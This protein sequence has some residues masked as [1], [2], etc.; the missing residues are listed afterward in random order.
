MIHVRVAVV[1]LVCSSVVAAGEAVSEFNGK[2]AYSRGSMEGDCGQNVFGSFSLPIAD[3]FGFQADGLYTNVSDR[4][5]YGAGGHLFWR[6]WDKGL[7]GIA[8][9]VL[10]EDDID[11]GLIV[12]EGEY[13][14]N[15]F[16]VTAAAGVANIDY[17]ESVP[18][19]ESDPTDFLGSLGLRCYPLDDLMLAGAY[20]YV[21]DNSL[22]LGELEYQTPIDGLTLFAEFAGG[23]NDYEHALFG[24]QFYLGKSKSLIRRHREDDPPSIVQ[25]ALYAA[26]TYGAE[27]NRKGREYAE[28][29][30]TQYSGGSYGLTSILVTPHDLP[31]FPIP[32]E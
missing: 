6:D 24:L 20:V 29:Q 17:D 15:R 8:G 9:A 14:L 13:Y 25:R 28:S 32:S 1:L 22:I 5:F 12:A 11:A 31:V 10:D 3:N 26:G 23:E 16:T 2:I 4:D 18:F 21:F 7:L 30:G 27:Y 19:I